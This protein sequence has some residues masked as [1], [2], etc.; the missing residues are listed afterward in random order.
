MN[1]LQV[2]HG[3]RVSQ[4]AINYIIERIARI[5]IAFN[6]SMDILNQFFEIQDRDPEEHL[7]HIE[8]DVVDDNDMLVH[9]LLQEIQRQTKYLSK[10]HSGFSRS[11]LARYVHELQE[12]YFAI[13]K[14]LWGGYKYYDDIGV[15]P[16]LRS[17]HQCINQHVV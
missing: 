8:R 4:E 3:G 17:F 7:T 10:N 16:M 13:Y 1:S 11:Q 5:R 6:Q 15:E 2:Q 9:D 12:R 14:E